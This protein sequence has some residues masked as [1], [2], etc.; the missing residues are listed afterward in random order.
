MP[1]PATEIDPLICKALDQSFAD[2]QNATRERYNT[3]QE[4]NNLVRE[5]IR[6]AS[7]QNE[8]LNAK[9]A[10]Q[11]QILITTKAAD[12]LL[13]GGLANDIL[14]QRSAGGQPQ[15]GAADAGV[16][17]GGGSKA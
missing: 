14:A 1:Y 16:N 17:A 8:D 2:G 3:S 6:N 4:G 13:N 7:A 12:A 11:T 15:S 9:A 5:L 10:A